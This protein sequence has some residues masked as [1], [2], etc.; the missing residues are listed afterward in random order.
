MAPF[1]GKEVD[2]FPMW[3]GAAPE[4]TQNVMDFLGAKTEKEALYDILGMDY[5]TVRPKYIGTPFK[6]Y[7]DGTV[8]NE[9]GIRRGGYHWGQA[10]NHPLKDV[11]TVEEVEA[12]PF[13]KP[14]DWDPK[15]CPEDL[16]DCEGYCVIG[17]TWA[18]FFHDSIELIGM[19]RFFIE[20]YMNPALAQAIVEHTF[21]FYY[22]VSKRAFEANPGVIDFA[23]IGNDFGSQKGLLMS[24]DMWRKFFKPSLAKY[25]E[26][27]HKHG[28]VAGL[29]SCGDI[30]EIIGDLIEIG[31][32]AV[33]PI[34]VFA[35]NMDPQVLKREYGGDIVFFGGI[36]VNEVLLYGSE[37]DVRAETRRIIDILG[38]DGQYIVAPSH[39]YMLPE[40]PA[41]NIVALY[42]EAKKYGTGR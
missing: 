3:Y 24:P 4:T 12:Y 31:F 38:S 11:E 21:N 28:A 10:L 16:Q 26:L 27:A 1:R 14:E 41:R 17:G 40:L 23:F 13:P 42:D 35:H 20:M 25:V 29:H 18:P 9:W 8:D 2:R 6:Q 7:E 39:D 22:E 19:E 34:Q 33:N 32:D 5:K 37:E 30:H 15:I 36:D